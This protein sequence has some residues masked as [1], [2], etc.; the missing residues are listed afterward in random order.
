ML[1]KLAVSS[2]DK[3]AAAGRRPVAITGEAVR[4]RVHLMRAMSDA[5]LIGIGTARAD[6][7]QLTCRLP[8]MAARSPTRVVLDRS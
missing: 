5:V 4:S 7:P 3:I 1:L 2:D 6:D 8:G